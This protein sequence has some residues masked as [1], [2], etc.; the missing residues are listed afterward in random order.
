MSANSTAPLNGEPLRPMAQLV[1]RYSGARG[2]KRPHPSTPIR[3]ATSGA[4]AVDGRVVKL[5]AVR[6]GCR[7]LSSE[8]AFAR[9][10]TAL[11]TPLGQEPVRSP[12]SR[13]R[14][15]ERAAAELEKMGA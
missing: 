1:A 9:F 15:S 8:A 5:E 14:A 12:A 3:W 4:R 10:M 6:L 2:A 11:A 13:N 7:W